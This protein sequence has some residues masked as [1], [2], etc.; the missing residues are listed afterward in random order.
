MINVPQMNAGDATM[1]HA[2]R[3]PLLRCYYWTKYQS[4]QVW[5]LITTTVVVASSLSCDAAQVS[6]VPVYS[7]RDHPPEGDS[8]ALSTGKFTGGAW[9]VSAPQPAE[10]LKAALLRA[11][12]SHNPLRPEGIPRA[13]AWHPRWRRQVPRMASS[14]RSATPS[15]FEEGQP[16]SQ[17]P[18][19]I[20]WGPT[21]SDEEGMDASSADVG[22]L[23][24]DFGHVSPR[25]MVTPFPNS[26]LRHPDDGLN[27]KGSP[28][29]LKP[30]LFG[31]RTEGIDPQLYVTIS[32]SV[33]IVLVAT[34]IILKF[35]WDRNQ[36]RRNHSA[37]QNPLQPE[38]SQQPL[39]DLS[40]GALSV[41]SYSESLKF[42]PELEALAIQEGKAKVENASRN[43]V[44]QLNRIPLVKL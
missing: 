24:L 42:T 1:G 12:R 41:F 26:R 25:G 22:S 9:T 23:H 11:V 8:W 21:V 17:Y 29:T 19:A 15:G 14:P 13:E 28:A 44:F 7:H 6:P 39:T 16:S 34:G 40:P 30:F 43:P 10:N 37:Q 36:K 5:T 38:D 18:W 4:F 27:L 32:I 20:V 31:P 3:H 35:C 33:I 2:H